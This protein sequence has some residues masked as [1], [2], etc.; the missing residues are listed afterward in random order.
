MASGESK[1]VANPR[2]TS[3]RAGMCKVDNIS[4]RTKENNNNLSKVAATQA[5][6]VKDEKGS[7]MKMNLNKKTASCYKDQ[8]S[9]SENYGGQDNY[10]DGT[11]CWHSREKIMFNN[12]D[13]LPGK[14]ESFYDD[15]GRRR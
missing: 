5:K 13:H 3:A 4:W 7:E 8:Y 14:I 6:T 12:S 11:L 9:I 10:S 15:R 1:I 2:R